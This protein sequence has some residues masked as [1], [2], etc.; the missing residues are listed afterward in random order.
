MFLKIYKKMGK[1]ILVERERANGHFFV[2]LEIYTLNI[3]FCH[4]GLFTQT[5]YK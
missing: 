5:I 1:N 3:F 4:I 2:Y